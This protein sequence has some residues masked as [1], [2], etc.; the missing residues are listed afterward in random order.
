MA[1]FIVTP[2]FFQA[3]ERTRYQL[4]IIADATAAKRGEAGMRRRWGG[5]KLVVRNN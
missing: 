5:I 3:A 4:W 1:V 2:G